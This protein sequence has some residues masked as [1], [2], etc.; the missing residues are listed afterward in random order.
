[1]GW[2]KHPGHLRDTQQILIGGRSLGRISDAESDPAHIGFGDVIV[3]GPVDMDFPVLLED[4]PT[5]NLFVYSRE[6]A[7]AEKFEALVALNI[8]TS[9]MKDIY[10][11]L[12]LAE[13][14]IFSLST[15]REAIKVTFAR[16]STLLN[17]DR[18]LLFS[19]GFS[20]LIASISFF[21][22]ISDLLCFFRI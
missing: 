21:S 16:R 11:I 8:L 10:D 4:Q 15:L 18:C 2:I 5:P 13:R 17:K 12:F 19:A 6:S 20:A 7:I 1:M 3:A 14:E 22:A 9:R